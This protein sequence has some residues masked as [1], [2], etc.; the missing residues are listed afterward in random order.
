MPNILALGNRIMQFRKFVEDSAATHNNILHTLQTLSVTL[1]EEIPQIESS[2][3][4]LRDSITDSASA[5]PKK[6]RRFAY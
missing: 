3:A 1:A 2:I 4:T 5:T 6:A